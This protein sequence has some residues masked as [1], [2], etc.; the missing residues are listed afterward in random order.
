[1]RT[2]RIDMCVRMCACMYDARMYVCLDLYE[3]MPNWYSTVCVYVSVHVC[4]N[5]RLD[6]YTCM[7]PLLHLYTYKYVRIDMSTCIIHSVITREHI[8]W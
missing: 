2:C 1:M 5:V 6:L 3:Y 4:M 8:P 7:H